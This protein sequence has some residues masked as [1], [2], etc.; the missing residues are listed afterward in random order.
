MDRAQESATAKLTDAQVSRVSCLSI[1][2]G[3]G[4]GGAMGQP[5]TVALP[6]GQGITSALPRTRVS[7]LPGPAMVRFSKGVVRPQ[8]ANSGTL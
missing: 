7:V 8:F 5:I 2:P 3:Y 4:S 6:E 1:L